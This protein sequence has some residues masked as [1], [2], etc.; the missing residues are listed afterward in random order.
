MAVTVEE[1]AI[2]LRVSSD[3][4]D[5]DLGTTGLLA[6]LLGVGDAHVTL[7]IPNAPEAIKSEVIVRLAAYLHDQPIG[8]RDAYA[9]AW[10]NSGAGSL[11]SRWLNQRVAGGP[12][13]AAAAPAPA[14]GGGGGNGLSTAAVNE[15]I[16]VHQEI[17]NAHFDHSDSSGGEHVDQEARAAATAARAVADAQTLEQTAHAGDA[18]AH[19]IPS[20]GGDGGVFTGTTLAADP[21]SMRL[22]WSQS[23]AKAAGN[24]TRAADHPVDGANSGLSS[25]LLIPPFPPSLNTDSSLY[26][27][28]WLEGDP[29]VAQLTISNE[30]ATLADYQN[31]GELV[32]E[33]DTGTAYVSRERVSPPEDAGATL[34][35]ILSGATIASEPWVEEQIAAIPAGGGGFTPEKIFTS[36]GTISKN[37]RFHQ[38]ALD[39]DAW[40]QVLLKNDRG[41]TPM[42]SG[43]F[44]ESGANRDA[45][46]VRGWLR[47]SATSYLEFEVRRNG[48]NI[49]F[50]YYGPLSGVAFGTNLEVWKYS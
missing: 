12:A 34:G 49:E 47:G 44:L 1:L 38:E 33:G 26:Q 32:V 21:V 48:T 46:Y 6:R 11:A 20:I 23:Q 43:K 28:L 30:D 35:L 29:E 24:F 41:L 8:R 27:W 39:P 42:I 16:R 22:G 36:S 2:A 25:G 5:L 9:N 19:H 31:Q 10:I 17:A 37:N 14:P 3:G 4:A 40:Y 18:N 50:E 13:A 15:L 7:L 45:V